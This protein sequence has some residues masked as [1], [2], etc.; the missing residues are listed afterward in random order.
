MS[1]SVTISISQ[2]TLDKLKKAHNYQTNQEVVRASIKLLEFLTEK[3]EKYPDFILFPREED[4]GKIKP[5][6][7][8][9]T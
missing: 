7:V 6:A 8:R 3:S 4:E 9:I 5:L 2:E 1:K